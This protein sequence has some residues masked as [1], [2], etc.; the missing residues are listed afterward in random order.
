MAVA[1]VILILGPAT[2]LDVSHQSPLCESTYDSI[3]MDSFDLSV[4]GLC[5]RYSH[6]KVNVAC[7]MPS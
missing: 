2:R 1:T 6:L 4:V 7:T 5:W 3:E